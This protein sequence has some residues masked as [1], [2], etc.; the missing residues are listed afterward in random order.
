MPKRDLT[1]RNKAIAKALY[2]DKRKPGD[3]AKEFKLSYSNVYRAAHQG[4]RAQGVE[5]FQSQPGIDSVRVPVGPLF[6]E[7]STTGLRRFGGMIDDDYLRIFR[8][9]NKKVS[10]YREMGDDPI[11]AAVL[12]AIR[13]RLR[14]VGWHATPG[15]DSDADKEAAE[16]LETCMHDMSQ[17]WADSIDQAL[18]MMQYG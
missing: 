9:L 4:A 11:V 3:I 8:S 1:Q 6:S 15:W 7:Q 10:I 16:W 5:S 14:A 18:G 13:M 17:T 12:Q 2:T